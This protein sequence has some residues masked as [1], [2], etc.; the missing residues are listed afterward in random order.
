MS[1]DDELEARSIR[2]RAPS[3]RKY[4]NI[5]VDTT[6]TFN[7]I[8]KDIQR[9]N[10]RIDE[11]TKSTENLETAIESLQQ[12]KTQYMKVIDE[13]EQ[14]SLQD[15]WGE[16]KE[17]KKTV[18]V[19]GPKYLNLLESKI[20]EISS[21][22]EVSHHRHEQSRTVRA[23]SKESIRSARTRVSKASSSVERICGDSSGTEAS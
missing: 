9:Q 18:E 1:Q 6:F 21:V 19:V 13:L 14:L 7:E 10:K 16:S 20:Q 15:K 23:P 22:K 3:R 12:V 8:T 2:S 4:E 11:A 17:V 5:L